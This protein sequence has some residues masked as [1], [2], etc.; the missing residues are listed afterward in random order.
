MDIDDI[1]RVEP[2]FVHIDRYMFKLTNQRGDIQAYLSVRTFEY[3]LM[4][5]S[6][7]QISKPEDQADINDKIS[8]YVPVSIKGGYQKSRKRSRTFVRHIG[9]LDGESQAETACFLGRPIRDIR[10]SLSEDKETSGCR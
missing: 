10:N 4:K 9:S 2:V 8:T 1:W 6:D 3:L 7:Y 5:T